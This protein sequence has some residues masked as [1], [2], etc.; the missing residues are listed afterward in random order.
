MNHFSQIYHSVRII[1]CMVLLGYLIGYEYKMLILQEATPFQWGGASLA[2]IG[3]CCILW[4]VA[5]GSTKKRK[6]HN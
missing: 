3:W 4:K 2:L 5:F 6:R 1:I